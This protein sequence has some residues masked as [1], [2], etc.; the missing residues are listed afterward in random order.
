MTHPQSQSQSEP[1]IDSEDFLKVFFTVTILWW[2]LWLQLLH[3]TNFIFTL[4][5]FGMVKLRELGYKNPSHTNR[6][7]LSFSL[8]LSLSLCVCVC[9]CVCVKGLLIDVL[10][11]PLNTNS[12]L[13]QFGIQM[14]K[15]WAFCVA[16]FY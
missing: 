9:V 7:F 1:P 6:V 10:L 14:N 4:K 12:N 8:S 16:N 11:H 3:Q 2:L 5:I 13:S 15:L